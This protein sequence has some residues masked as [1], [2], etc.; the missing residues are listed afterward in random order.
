MATYLKHYTTCIFLI[1]NDIWSYVL[2]L[3][4]P[5]L[6]IF[7]VL[8]V[9][10]FFFFIYIYWNL[11]LSSFVPVTLRHRA[12][13]VPWNSWYYPWSLYWFL[14]WS[15]YLPP[16]WV[17]QV[18]LITLSPN[19][20][21]PEKLEYILKCTKSLSSILHSPLLAFLCIPQFIFACLYPAYIV[22][23]YLFI[24]YLRKKVLDF[25]Q[26]ACLSGYCSAFS[27]KP[28]HYSLSP[29]LHGKCIEMH[30]V[31]GHSAIPVSCDLGGTVPLKPSGRH[32][33][34]SSDGEQATSIEH[35]A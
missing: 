23:S 9:R 18:R 7:L 30:H 35:T 12:D 2:C 19:G 20:R 29:Q 22:L 17:W 11:Y 8:S 27:Y 25:Y 24:M 31:P 3:S 15:W 1:Y 13:A 32:D 16:L 28:M 26:R 6:A 4:N 33:S 34:W 14:G 21:I 10:M 5:L